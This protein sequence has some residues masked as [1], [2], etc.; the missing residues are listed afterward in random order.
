MKYIRQ[1]NKMD[2]GP[3]CIAMVTSHYGKTLSLEYLRR[4][5][6]LTREGI[7]LLSVEYT[8]RKIGFETACGQF[9][10]DYLLENFKSPLILHWNSNHFVVLKK[11]I[12]IGQTTRPKIA[13]RLA[14]K[15]K[16]AVNSNPLRFYAISL[17]F[18]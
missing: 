14:Q 5:S 2:C 9:T 1:E 6:Q 3:S 15:T 12:I 11:I 7:S 17:L 10:I 18:K 16:N 4:E 13:K 8:C